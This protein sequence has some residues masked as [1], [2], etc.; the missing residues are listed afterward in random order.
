MVCAKMTTVVGLGLPVNHVVVAAPAVC[1]STAS[2]PCNSMSLCK[3]LFILLV[4]MVYD[5]MF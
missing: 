3:I 5:L 1:T 4:G 2:A